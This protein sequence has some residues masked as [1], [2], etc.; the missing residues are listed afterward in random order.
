MSNQSL[1]T[2]SSQEEAN[3]IAN[4]PSS[5][6]YDLVPGE[7]T[8]LFD[9]AGESA[10]RVIGLDDGGTLVLSKRAEIGALA[11][12]DK[13]RLRR[14]KLCCSRKRTRQRNTC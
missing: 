4:N 11:K 13:N 5:E 14:Q 10:S 9:V 3:S 12:P 2:S 6:E 1:S 7:R 8:E